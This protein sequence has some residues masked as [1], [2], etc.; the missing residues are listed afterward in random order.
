VAATTSPAGGTGALARQRRGY[1][2]PALIAMAVLLAIGAAIGAGDLTH[3]APAKL[4]GSTVASQIAVGIEQ[5][6]RTEAPPEVTCPPTIP[7]RTGWQ[8][9]CTITGPRSRQP[10]TV[11]EID[12]RGGLSWHLGR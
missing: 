6:G 10:V 1:A 4:Q 9:V 5:Q 3:P 2:I 12:N 8:F 11:R 7:V